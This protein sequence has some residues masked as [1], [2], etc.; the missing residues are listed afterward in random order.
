MNPLLRSPQFYQRF[1][2]HVGLSQQ[3][4]GESV[5]FIE[6]PVLAAHPPGMVNRRQYERYISFSCCTK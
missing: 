3:R 5:Q 4:I 1:F 2:F 6:S